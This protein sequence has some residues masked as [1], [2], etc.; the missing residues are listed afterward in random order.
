MA[1]SAKGSGKGPGSAV[2]ARQE[3]EVAT[4]TKDGIA[5]LRAKVKPTHFT[6]RQIRRAIVE[7]VRA[8][9]TKS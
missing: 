8:N 4:V 1:P 7:D 6:S 2:R 9:A 3:Y 5:I